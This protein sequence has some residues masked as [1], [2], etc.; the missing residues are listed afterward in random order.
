M[1]KRK[2]KVEIKHE[3]VARDLAMGKTKGDA[4]RDNGYSE[5][6][7]LSPKKMLRTESFQRT[8]DRV[9]SRE[10]V[11]DQHMKLYKEHRDIKQVRLETLDDKVINKV[12]EGYPNI[13]VLKNPEEGY[14]LLIINEVNRRARRESIELAYKLRGDFSSIKVEVKRDHEDMTDGELLAILKDT[15]D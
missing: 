10:Y 15:G 11:L 5:P 2:G 8:L 1:D 9:M 7:A 6:A 4:I 14:T 3:K 13:S 12:C